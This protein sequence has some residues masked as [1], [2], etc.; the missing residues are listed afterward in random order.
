MVWA[1]AVRIV[2]LEAPFMEDVEAPPAHGDHLDLREDYSVAPMAV[3]PF[4]LGRRTA[5]GLIARGCALLR[6]SLVL[7]ELPP[8]PAWV[9]Q[10]GHPFIMPTRPSAIENANVSMS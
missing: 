1:T 3:W 8:V 7:G 5:V 4:D 6:L 10:V 9:A 2:Q